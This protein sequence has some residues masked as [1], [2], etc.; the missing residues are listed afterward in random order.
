MGLGADRGKKNG[1]GAQGRRTG[2][3]HA[4]PAL[5]GNRGGF[6][7]RPPAHLRRRGRR[8]AG[9][10]LPPLPSLPTAKR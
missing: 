2:G 5:G 7:Q 6:P 8:F 9:G 3:E 4:G 10:D 1:Q